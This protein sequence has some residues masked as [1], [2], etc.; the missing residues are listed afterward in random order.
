MSSGYLTHQLRD[1]YIGV[2][3]V[4]LALGFAL[5]QVFAPL[6]AYST[7]LLQIIFFLTSLHIQLSGIWH[8]LKRWPTILLVSS[9]MLLALPLLV[10]GLTSPWLPAL[11]LPLVLLATMPVGMT[12]PLLVQFFGLNTS[13][14]LVLTLTTSLLAPFT[15][16][17]LLTLLAPA[18][19]AIDLSHLFLT[20]FQVMIIPFVVAQ[21]VRMI[22]PEVGRATRRVYKPVAL[23]LVGCLIAAI[24]GKYQTAFL[25]AINME[26]LLGL[27]VMTL[28]F[29][30]VHILGYWLTWWR[31]E[32]DRLTVTLCVVYMNF[33]LAIFIA[34][35]F[36]PDP[37]VVLYTILSILPWNIGIVL[38]RKVVVE[39]V[40]S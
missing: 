14:A 36:F 21:I 39:R 12:S 23:F 3:L 2:L 6:Q 30:L 40:Q 20:L 34:E 8:E 38:F 18:S 17:L 26:T 31:S 28:F 4:A 33:T 5:P 19:V 9:F 25:S 32:T 35:K 16:P 22:W 7:E 27:G 37:Q 15:V 13:L 11:A 1:S 10:Y 29:L 24:A